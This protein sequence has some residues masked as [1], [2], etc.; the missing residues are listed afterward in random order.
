VDQTE[1]AYVADHVDGFSDLVVGI[2]GTGT[3][4]D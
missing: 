4:E 1:K 2:G 3:D